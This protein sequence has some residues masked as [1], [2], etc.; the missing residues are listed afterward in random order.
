MVNSLAMDITE[1]L[2]M[3]ELNHLS[4]QHQDE[5]M[6]Y[7]LFSSHSFPMEQHSDQS[8]VKLRSRR[9]CWRS[10]EVF[11]PLVIQITSQFHPASLG[12]PLLKSARGMID[13]RVTDKLLISLGHD[14]LSFQRLRLSGGYHRFCIRVTI[15]ISASG[16]RG[17]ADDSSQMADQKRNS[18]QKEILVF[19][20]LLYNA[21]RVRVRVRR[22]LEIVTLPNYFQSTLSSIL[23]WKIINI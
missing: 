11:E 15:A 2:H 9:L 6:I 10:C 4:C 17:S 7:I 5:I 1:Y 8:G 19:K 23:M 3:T 13:D 20:L 21:V 14:I 12:N 18:K 16:R 22:V